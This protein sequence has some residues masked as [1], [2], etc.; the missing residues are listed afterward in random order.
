[1]RE[2]SR[3]GASARIVG[4]SQYQHWIPAFA[5]MTH[6]RC[7]STD[8]LVMPAQAGIERCLS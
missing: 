3:D 4:Q 5:G 7:A 1:M 2:S 8:C 6:I